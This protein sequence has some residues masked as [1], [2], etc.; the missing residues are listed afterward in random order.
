MGVYDTL[1]LDPPLVCP[2]CGKQHE[3]LQT[4]LF[5]CSLATYRPGMIIPGSP[6]HTGVLKDYIDCCSTGDDRSERLDVYIV[7]WH[8]VYA[9]SSLDPD[10]AQAR[11]EKLD[12]MDLLGWLDTMQKTAREWMN[13]Y[14]ALC[15]DLSDWVE[16]RD[17]T[18]KEAAHGNKAS[19]K[20]I[21]DFRRGMIVGNLTEELLQ[22][23][24]PLRCILERNRE[25]RLEDSGFFGL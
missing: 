2:L 1:A 9:A 20:T 19:E 15:R 25:D 21:Q 16:F 7:I 11:L 3:S 22:D 10:S 6:V 8:G 4:H 17:M 5:D 23:P 18:A 14:R 12:R 24:D 13:R